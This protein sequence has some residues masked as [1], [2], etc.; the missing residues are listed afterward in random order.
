MVA[1]FVSRVGL[2][3]NKLKLTHVSLREAEPYEMSLGADGKNWT[4]VLLS[5]RLS[6]KVFYF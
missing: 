2:P 6:L 4:S 1:D 5:R 3:P